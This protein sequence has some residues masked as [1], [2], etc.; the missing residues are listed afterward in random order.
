MSETQAPATPLHDIAQSLVG[1]IAAGRRRDL[2]RVL[3][4]LERMSP[5][6]SELLRLL[7][8][9]TGRASVLGVT[10]PPGAGKSTLVNSLIRSWRSDG[11]RVAVIAVD[12]SSPISGGAIL[13]DRIRMTSALDDDGVFV[14]SLASGG[15]LGGLSPAAVRMVDALDAAG[16]NLILL[17]TV[18]TGQSEID[19]AEVA[20]VRVVIAAPGLGDD[21]QA[22]K[23]GLLEIADV[24]VVNKADSPLAER[25]L[26]QLAGALSIRAGRHRDVPL[27][28]TVAT[29]GVGVGELAGVIDRIG[30]QRRAEPA[31][32]RRRRRARYLIAQAASQLIRDAFGSSDPAALNSLA[33]AVLIGARAPADAARRLL[34]TRSD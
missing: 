18:G 16:F 15:H 1:G 22:M 26:Q 31:A 4:E 11:R 20:D 29:S 12:P 30:I 14:R 17:E 33:D 25:T 32:E 34:G 19:V 3:T 6:A 2:A 7:A 27:L 23:S 21:I 28:K 9:Q 13:G 5:L 8:P 24:L 10:G